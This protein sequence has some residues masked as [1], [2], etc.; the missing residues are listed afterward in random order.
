MALA[1]KAPTH[2]AR[3][4]KPPF[5]KTGADRRS[6]GL[7]P[8]CRTSGTLGNS[9]CMSRQAQERLHGM[10]WRKYRCD[11]P[12]SQD[13]MPMIG[14]FYLCFLHPP[15]LIRFCRTN[16]K[17]GKKVGVILASA[18]WVRSGLKPSFNPLPRGV[19]RLEVVVCSNVP[20]AK[21]AIATIPA[22]A[23]MNHLAGFSCLSF[24][25]QS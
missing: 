12:I 24:G 4:W 10:R 25:T 1:S 16:Q 6:A 17:V 22:C 3:F 13:I 19:V 23:A 20:D 21:L 14:G 15:F 18:S 8:S 7:F 9:R 5:P 11:R 2:R